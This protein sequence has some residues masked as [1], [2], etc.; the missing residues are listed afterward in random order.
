MPTP[1]S[2][3]THLMA[4]I[5][6]RS[7]RRPPATDGHRVCAA[8]GCKTKLTRYNRSNTCYAHQVRRYPRIRGQRSSN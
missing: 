1:R 6:P 2:T 7:G 8:R 5:P 3:E 4:E